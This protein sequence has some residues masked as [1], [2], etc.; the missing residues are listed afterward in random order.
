MPPT[1]DEL[2]R[3]ILALEARVRRL[4][5]LQTSETARDP[6]DFIFLEPAAPT[7]PRTTATTPRPASRSTLPQLNVTQLLGWAGVT[8]LVLAVAYLIKL[9]VDLGW[10]TPA[11][12]IILAV[13]SGAAL[14]GSGIALRAADRHYASLLPAGGVVILFLAAYGAHLYYR[15]IPYPA[16]TLAKSEIQIPFKRFTARRTHAM[17]LLKIF[18]TNGL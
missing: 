4:E 16:A 14:I 18:G 2:K 9:G 17:N 10:L 7:P 15:L 6:G 12:Q 13:V 1:E 5:A 3:Q 8:A 11:R